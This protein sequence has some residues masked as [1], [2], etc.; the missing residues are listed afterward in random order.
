MAL[1]S[2]A[3][4][5]KSVIR[6]RPVRREMRVTHARRA[7]VRARARAWQRVPR[8]CAPDFWVV[9]RNYHKSWNMTSWWRAR[10]RQM[11]QPTDRPTDRGVGHTRVRVMAAGRPSSLPPSRSSFKIT[12]G[13]L[14]KE[15][16]KISPFLPGSLIDIVRCMLCYTRACLFNDLN[17]IASIA[18]N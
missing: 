11:E 12:T 1:Q 6:V 4:P 8:A 3:C 5:A 13:S 9:D 14:N 15:I 10:V 18:G 2:P 7:H 17:Q 16:Y